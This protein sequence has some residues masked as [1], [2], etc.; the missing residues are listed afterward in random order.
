MN[1]EDAN[2]L[3]VEDFGEL[4]DSYFPRLY[5]YL[6]YRVT[7]RQDAE[8]LVAETFLKAVKA[9]PRFKAEHEYS[10]A[11]WLFRIAHN[12]LSNF[13]RQQRHWQE[14]VP[15]EIA[16]NLPATDLAPEEI[17]LQQERALHVRRLLGGLAPR[18]QEVISLKYF[19]G[20]RNQ[21]IAHIMELDE[22]TVSAYLN[23][24]LQ[25][26]QQRYLTE[27]KSEP[28]TLPFPALQRS[29]MNLKRLDAL[30]VQYLRPVPG[31]IDPRNRAIPPWLG[32]IDS[33]TSGWFEDWS[34]SSYLERAIPRADEGFR[35]RL[36]SYLLTLLK[37]AS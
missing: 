2:N 8:D 34:V 35:L 23:R 31:E 7:S 9:F 36:K 1:K 4:Y 16:E 18:Q 37:T 29:S 10:V 28:D 33:V 30:T 25:E 15:L 6:S 27:Q 20:L 17:L 21:E 5:A 13:R 12:L 19:G 32:G 22:R 26:L 11:A 14:W 24:G 3:L